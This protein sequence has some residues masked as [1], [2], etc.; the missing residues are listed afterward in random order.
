MYT[1][2]CIASS[3]EI[4]QLGERKTE[5]LKVTGSIPVFGI[6]SLKRLRPLF[7]FDLLIYFSHDKSDL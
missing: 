4:A 5:A 3:A 2:I 6:R 1:K 7:G